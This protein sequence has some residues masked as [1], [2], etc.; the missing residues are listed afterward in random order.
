M[1]YLLGAIR[2]ITDSPMNYI[3]LKL[4][5]RIMQELQLCEVDEPANDE[6]IF[7]FQFKT[8]KTNIEKSSILRKLKTQLRKV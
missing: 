1:R 4:I 2:E 8:T 7:A 3:K 5:I 6:Y